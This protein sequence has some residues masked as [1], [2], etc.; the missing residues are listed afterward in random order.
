MS[1]SD[2]YREDEDLPQF[3]EILIAVTR[4]L[5][6]LSN[7]KVFKI[8][9]GFSMTE[10]IHDRRF[11]TDGIREV[12]DNLE[13]VVKRTGIAK[14]TAGSVGVVSGAAALGGLILAPFTAGVSLVLTVGGVV[15]GIASSATTLSAS[16]LKHTNINKK[17]KKVKELLDSLK[18]RD[19]IVCKV[20]E[21]LQKKIEKL[22]SL[23]EKKSVTSFIVDGGK[24]ASWAKTFGYNI[25]YKGYTVV[26]SVKAIKFSTAIARF[27]QA[28]VRGM[29]TGIAAP[30]FKV[31]GRTLLLAG[32]TIAKVLSGVFSVVGIAAGVW[33]IVDG[34][35][36]IKNGSKHAK[37]YRKAADELD[38]QTVEYEEL[39]IKI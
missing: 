20:M 34:A 9:H 24:I 21:D 13:R 22:R 32:S 33:D 29:A 28:D 10:Y 39:L 12:A 14:T 25:V 11:C 19:E 17:A 31:F 27:I 1:Y 4:I 2:Y 6:F 38:Q 5:G 3:K 16:V 15:G 30:G 36:D 35:L 23:Y 26:S 37:A 7:D 18:D 8:E